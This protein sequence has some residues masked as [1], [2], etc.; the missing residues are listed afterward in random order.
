MSLWHQTPSLEQINRS[1]DNTAVSQMGI[2]FTE[3]G[4]DFLVAR[5]D[6]KADRHRGVLM[7]P[8]AFSESGSDTL[9]VATELADELSLM[10]QWLGLGEIEVGRNGDLSTPLRKMLRP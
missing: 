10:A 3:V 8:G 4:D 5:V 2:E 6:L 1:H 7:V 9:H